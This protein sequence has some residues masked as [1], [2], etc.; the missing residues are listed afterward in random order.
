MQIEPGLSWSDVV[1]GRRLV[2]A[3]QDL[4]VEPMPDVA[5]GAGADVEPRRQALDVR[6]EHV[7]AAARDP[8]RVQGAEQDQVGGLASRAVDGADPDR[9]V[10]DHGVGW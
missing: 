2:H 1:L 7:L 3:D 6:G 10:V 8:H 5:L 4:R 9:Q